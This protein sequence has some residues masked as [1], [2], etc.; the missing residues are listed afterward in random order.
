MVMLRR[1]VKVRPTIQPHQH[2]QSG[3]SNQLS[4]LSQSNA[5]LDLT[6]SMA[7]EPEVSM[8][9]SREYRNCEVAQ[10]YDS[11]KSAKSRS[12]S[13]ILND[14]HDTYHHLAYADS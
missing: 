12:N 1:Q 4:L 14:S 11:L 8:D 9:K 3:F 10:S 13:R 2:A 5:E 6:N 7:I